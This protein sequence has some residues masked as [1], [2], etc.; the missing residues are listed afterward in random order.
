MMKKD[1][2]KEKNIQEKKQDWPYQ[3][4]IKIQ[5]Q[6]LPVKSKEERDYDETQFI[7]QDHKRI[8]KKDNS[9]NPLEFF[10]IKKRIGISDIRKN[11]KINDLFPVAARLRIDGKG[12]Q[13]WRKYQKS[14]FNKVGLFLKHPP[15]KIKVDGKYNSLQY[16]E[17]DLRSHSSETGKE[18]ETL[19]NQSSSNKASL[20]IDQPFTNIVPFTKPDLMPSILRRAA[21][22]KRSFILPFFL[23]SLMPILFLIRKNSRGSLPLSFFFIRL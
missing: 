18:I 3:S 13:K 7:G 22:G 17:I 23:M 5:L 15:R 9:K 16:H 21:T 6:F 8:K 2:K 11:R 20:I 14:I 19:P 4:L 1:K 10:L 12:E